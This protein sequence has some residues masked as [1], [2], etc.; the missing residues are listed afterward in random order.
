MRKLILASA[1]PR[2]REILEKMQIPFVVSVSDYEEDMSL[3]LKP[4]DLVR[5]FALGKAEAV[6]IKYKDAVIIGADTVIE[7]KG[8]VIGKP[9]TAERAREILKQLSNKKHIVHTGYCVIDTLSGKR[10]V[11][12]VET[13]VTFRKLS[14]AEINAYVVTKEP[15]L[16]AGAYMVQGRAASFVTRIEG[17]YFN[18]VGFPIA[19]IVPILEKCGIFYYK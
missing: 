17:D 4:R 7:W 5:R 6:A 3:P 12:S 13:K 8:K 9:Y 16:A 15:L 14:S 2:R 19:T 1:S 18:I 11:G 10:R